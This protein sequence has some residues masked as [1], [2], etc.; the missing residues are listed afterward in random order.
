M[1]NIGEGR[2]SAHKQQGGV[3]VSDIFRDHISVMFVG[4]L[5]IDGPKVCCGVDIDGS[6]FQVLDCFLQPEAEGS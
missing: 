1:Y 4:N 2:K 5:L 6:G 3:Q